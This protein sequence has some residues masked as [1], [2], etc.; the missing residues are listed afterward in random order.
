MENYV[1][2]LKVIFYVS[3]SYSTRQCGSIEGVKFMKILLTSKDNYLSLSNNVFLCLQLIAQMFKDMRDRLIT[4]TL[5]KTTGRFVT[6]KPRT[7]TVA[8]NFSESLLS[9]IETM[10]RCNPYFVRCVKPNS[11]KAPMQ[12]ERDV[13]LEQLRYTGM[14]ETIRIRKLGFPVRMKFHS[15][16]ERWKIFVFY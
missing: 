15:F 1:F 13:V 11:E 14:L 9:L 12:Y 6:M 3:M 2:Y 4:K 10:S 7:P 8:A 5:S 16:I